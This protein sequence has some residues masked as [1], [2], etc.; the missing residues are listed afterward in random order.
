MKLFLDS[1]HLDEISLMVSHIEDSGFLRFTTLG[2]FDPKTLSAQR[3]IVHGRKDVL[4]LIG[5]KPIHIMSDEERS[6][7]PK[8]ETFFIDLGLPK[9]KVEKLTARLRSSHGTRTVPSSS[10]C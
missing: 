4:G 8:V 6:K 3:V 1:A 7:M 2:G 5:S 9:A 10:M